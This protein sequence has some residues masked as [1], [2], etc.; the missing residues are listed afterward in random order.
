MKRAIIKFNNGRGALLC[1]RCR[2]ILKEDFNPSTIE[3]KEYFCIEC[4][5]VGHEIVYMDV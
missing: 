4:K 3:D 2:V 1:N 5:G